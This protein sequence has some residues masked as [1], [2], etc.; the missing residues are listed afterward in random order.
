MPNPAEAPEVPLSDAD[1]MLL[2]AKIN[3]RAAMMNAFA[4]EAGRE[5]ETFGEWRSDHTATRDGLWAE[6]QAL[7]NQAL[8][9][10]G[11]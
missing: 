4:M 11:E 10:E 6:I 3:A 7:E 5:L 1:K 2:A 9:G 8:L